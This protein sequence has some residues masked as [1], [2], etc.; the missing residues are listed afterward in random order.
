[1]KKLSWN[2]QLNIGVDVIDKAHARLFK[3]VG[4]LMD[5]VEYE[6][7]CENACR[8]SIRFL[9]DYTM[10]HF[11]QE[12]A[13]MRSIH[14]K[15]YDKHKKIHDDF[16]D[17]TLVSMKKYLEK[18]G[19][20][21][22]AVQRYISV[23]LGWLTGHIM[24]EDQA[25]MGNVEA[26]RV[27]EETPDIPNVAGAVN[28]AMKDVFH[29][30]AELADGDYNGGNIRN[31]YYYRL[32]YDMDNGGKVQILMVIE[33]QLARRGVGLMLGLSAMQNPEMVKET[34]MKIV[35]QFF[36]HLGKLFK[37]E[38]EYRLDKEESLTK[39]EFREDFMTRYPCSLLFET[40]LGSFVFCA[41]KWEVKRKRE[42]A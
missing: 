27:Y 11:S 15:E 6:T 9:E 29:L 19:Y 8:E 7:N 26:N 25:I 40:R 2:E 13:Y 39:D 34:S 3:M 37:S 18:S 36:H 42:N 4:K 35:E 23:L 5:L 38:T 41:R 12:E 31:G 21:P 1:M 17:N 20:S 22:M 16:R 10:T 28:Q 32:C 14:Y 30:S 33:E 24:M